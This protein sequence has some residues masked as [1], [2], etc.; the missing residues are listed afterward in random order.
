MLAACGS[1]EQFRQNLGVL[2]ITP[3]GP[4]ELTLEVEGGGLDDP[5]DTMVTLMNEGPGSVD[6]LTTR[7][8]QLSGEQD[9]SLI[10]G[11]ESLLPR[12][13]EVELIVRYSPEFESEA[14]A[15]LIVVV[16]GSFANEAWD[17]DVA[18]ILLNGVAIGVR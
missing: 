1:E 3:R 16:E 15:L 11:Y 4:I 6:I 14:E 2:N 13:Q 17:E 9:W 7:I 12:G 8:V 5:T 18:E 10:Q